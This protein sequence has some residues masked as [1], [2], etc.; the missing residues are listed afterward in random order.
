MIQRPAMGVL[1]YVGAVCLMMISSPV[2]RAQVKLEYKFPEG[3]KLTYKTTSRV[4]QVLA[5]MNNMN[6]ESVVRETKV[7]TRSVGKR[8]SDSTLP[9]EEKVEFLRNDY[10]LP[11]L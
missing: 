1:M 9:I 7:W 3:K 8:R 4:R 2:V 11:G 10:T 5:F 6:K